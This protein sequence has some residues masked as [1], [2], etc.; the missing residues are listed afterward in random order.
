MD[1][2]MLVKVVMLP[3]VKIVG[4]SSIRKLE[5]S[6]LDYCRV[7]YNR[8]VEHEFQHLYLTSS[9]EIKMGDWYI[10]DTNTVR[11]SMI[12]DKDYW[13]KRTHYRRIEATTDTSLRLP[14]I[15]EKFI[16]QYIESQ[17]SIK[18]T[19]V[20]IGDIAPFGHNYV[21][22]GAKV[23]CGY[24]VI[25]EDKTMWSRDEVI[26]NIELARKSLQWESKEDGI[27]ISEEWLYRVF[28][29]PLPTGL[30][31]NVKKNNL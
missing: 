18:E 23:D 24:I 9:E 2:K 11:K 8:G 28:G 14:L 20:A 3:T 27:F 13:A 5:H 19:Y 31:S 25:V 16:Q 26:E 15:R 21:I 1:D 4:R 30:R 10:D 12:S 22:L 17:G 6:R 7:Q 29:L